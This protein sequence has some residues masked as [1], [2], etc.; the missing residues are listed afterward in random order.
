MGPMIR[1]L[2][3]NEPKTYL[4]DFHIESYEETQGTA[5][6]GSGMPRRLYARLEDVLRSERVS[7][8][9]ISGASG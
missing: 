7:H 6:G 3:P 4:A 9:H 1:A 8:Q 2:K 5:D